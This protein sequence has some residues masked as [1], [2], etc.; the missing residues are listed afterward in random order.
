[1][2]SYQII[3]IGGHLGSDA[4]TRYTA[5]GA[6]LLQFSVAVGWSKK[7]RDSDEYEQKTAWYRVTWMGGDR[8]QRMAPNLV[9]GKAVTVFGRLNPDIWVPNDDREP[10]LNLDVFASD[11]FIADRAEKRDDDDEYEPRRDR[12]P[13]RQPAAA[14]APRQPATR[15]QEPEDLEDLP[16]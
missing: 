15:R 14:A 3:T 8:A 5:K 16:F 13:Q 12:Q 7:L 11:V 1:M 2:Q 4:E 9:S 10:R 6:P